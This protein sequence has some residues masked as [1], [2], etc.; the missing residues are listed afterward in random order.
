QDP[1]TYSAERAF[2]ARYLAEHPME[3]RRYEHDDE[4]RLLSTLIWNMTQPTSSRTWAYDE[5]GNQQH[6]WSAI[7]YDYDH[8]NR[9]TRLDGT[10]TAVG[11]VVWT[12]DGK[13]ANIHHT[14]SGWGP[15]LTYDYDPE[16]RPLGLH[17]IAS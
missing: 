7:E 16:G 8:A 1:S 14:P 4:G 6:A 11:N 10:A 13:I 3:F 2:V 17:E 5:R 9:P 15:T 12:H